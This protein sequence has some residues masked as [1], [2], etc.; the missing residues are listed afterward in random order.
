MIQ[1]GRGKSIFH[2][3]S[4]RRREVSSWGKARNKTGLAG[5]PKV[6][7]RTGGNRKLRSQQAEVSCSK[8]AHIPGVGARA[9]SSSRGENEPSKKK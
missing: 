6:E 9:A 3:K 7:G 5:V 4:R 8:N 2:P 1:E